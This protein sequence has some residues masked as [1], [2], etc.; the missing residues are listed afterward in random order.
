MNV[1]EKQQRIID[2]FLLI[3]D[4]MER[5]QLIVDTA[6]S[7]LR[8][9]PASKKNDE[10]LIPGC[11]SQVWI[12]EGDESRPDNFDLRLES[13]APALRGVVSLFCELYS[14]VP[15]REVIEVEPEFV[16]TLKIDSLLTPTRR[17]GLGFIRESIRELAKESCNR[18]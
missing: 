3:E 1:R 11:R 9:F 4:P 10:S 12:A 5:F 18:S 14:G 15:A 6:G 8:S 16:S 7:R 13:D 17:R 2:D